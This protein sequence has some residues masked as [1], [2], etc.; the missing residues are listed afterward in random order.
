[1]RRRDFIAVISAAAVAWPIA[2]RA[3]QAAPKIARIGWL[4]AGLDAEQRGA[5]YRG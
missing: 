3:Q 1:M 4:D 2:V 5:E